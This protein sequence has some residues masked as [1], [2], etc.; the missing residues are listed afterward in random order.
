MSIQIMGGKRSPSFE[1]K[2]AT[3]FYRLGAHIM[4]SLL[5]LPELKD[6]PIDFIFGHVRI[7]LSRLLDS[8]SAQS[9]AD[10]A[11]MM[12]HIVVLVKSVLVVESLVVAEV[13]QGM[14]L[15]I[16]IHDVSE[17]VEFLLEHQHWFVI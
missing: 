15:L 5:V 2:Q 1:Y 17:F 11:E 6:V 16:M 14:V 13:T 3:G 12:I 9:L 4:F 7:L 10:L 8:L